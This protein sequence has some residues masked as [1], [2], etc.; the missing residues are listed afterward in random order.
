M[1]ERA[2]FVSPHNSER[3]YCSKKGRERRRWGPSGSVAPSSP[4][5]TKLGLE[6]WIPGITPVLSTQAADGFCFYK[7]SP[8]GPADLQ[9]PYTSGFRRGTGSK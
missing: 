7:C 3:N 5:G 6:S 4:R 8:V 1:E 2:T 9:V